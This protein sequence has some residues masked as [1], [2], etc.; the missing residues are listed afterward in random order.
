M[1]YADQPRFVGYLRA[2][3]D[4]QSRSGLGLEAQQAA[5]EQYVAGCRG[6]MVADFIEIESGRRADRPKLVEALRLCRV[7]GATLVIA[8]LDRLARNVAFISHLMDGAV[9]FVA[10]DFPMANRLTLHILAAVAEHEAHIIRDRTRTALTAAKAR[11]VKLGGDRGNLP[12]VARSGAL[13]SALA[14]RASA[15]SRADDLRPIIDD[16]VARQ[17]SLR[18]I[19][20]ELTARSIP[21]PRGGTWGASQ[22]FRLIEL[23][24]STA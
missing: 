17:F 13:A 22:V 10:V 7:H 19:A 15:Q 3:T 24:K 9:E 6:I 11:G 20:R 16:L 14:R 8:K 4:K 5:V 18:G 12:S 23:T 21:A 2:S 1:K